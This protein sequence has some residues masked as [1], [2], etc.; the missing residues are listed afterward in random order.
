MAAINITDLSNA[1]TDVA[2]IGEIA[3]SEEL[4]ATDRLGRTK[5]T[6]EGKLA[7][8]DTA[9]QAKEAEFD[10]TVAD[11]ESDLN[12]YRAQAATSATEAE[13][14]RALAV[15]AATE[16]QT[17]IP[18]VQKADYAALRAYAGTATRL[19]VTGYLVT[20]APQGIVGPFVRD[21][22]DT[23]SQDN[24]GTIIVADNG[25]RW[26]RSFDGPV[27]TGWFEAHGNGID[28]DYAGITAAL[29][30][31]GS[32]GGGVVRGR[33]GGAHRIT[34]GLVIDVMGVV[35]DLNGARL[36]A[37]FASGWAVTVGDGTLIEHAGVR[38]GVI[39]TSR[40]ETTL[41]GV[42]F[43]KDARRQVAYD[44]LRIKNFK[45][46]GFEFEQLNWS[47]PQGSAPLIEHCGTNF[48]INDNGNAITI[49][50]MGLD[51]ADTYNAE[52]R[53][54]F[55]VTFVGGYNQNA[56]VAGVL[57]DVGTVGSMQATTALSMVGVYM[58]HNGANHVLARNGKGFY[59]VGNYL[60]CAGMS[61]AAF[62]FESWTGADIRG[63]TPSSLSS[64]TA[65]D[66]VEADASCSLI[67]VGKQNVTTAADTQVC[68]YGGSKAGIVEAYG[69]AIGT[70]PTAGLLNL[71]SMVLYQ[72]TAGTGV[73]RSR[74]YMSMGIGS[75]SRAF[76]RIATQPR[77]MGAAGAVSPYTPSLTN[78]ET[79]DLTVPNTGL[80]INAPSG[81]YEDGD[82]ISFL[83]RQDS[84]GGGAITWNVAYK[85][86]L[87]NTG[88]AANTY[89]SVSFTWSA[90]RSLWVQTAAM[91]WTA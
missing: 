60:N 65:R 1:K 21:D 56:G 45:G 70:L 87:A 72:P 85:T 90:G 53:G 77:K 30:Y 64:G 14:S 36:V 74:P 61:G 86:N 40:S 37:D 75:G 9:R 91:P 15:V 81:A 71:S 42:R 24:G 59:A 25:K 73:N 16:A 18:P 83:L 12:V 35:F 51:G 41:N 2:H 52:I 8:F 26:K 28:D 58:E 68:F 19:D 55:A 88:N 17:A 44:K 63:N 49:A 43:R 39:D 80:T 67:A 57:A 22:S 32:V 23:T 89:A 47:I 38:N 54:A 34:A 13:T 6:L 79:F 33:A 20:A 82:S 3:N 66:F 76:V 50:G 78:F 84:T 10:A 29:A 7:Q 4:T 62:K 31:V 46:C 5:D 11:A 69:N 27:E 48:R